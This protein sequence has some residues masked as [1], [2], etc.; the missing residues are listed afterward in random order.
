M[1][2]IA[3]YRAE[4]IG[5]RQVL[6]GS[7]R[8]G[9][10]ALRQGRQ[11]RHPA[12]EPAGEA[13]APPPPPEAAAPAALEVTSVFAGLVSLAVAERESEAASAEAASAEAANAAPERVA[14]PPA[15]AP[16]AEAPP[17]DAPPADAP[18][19]AGDAPASL[20]PDPPLAE[21]GFGPGMLIRLSQLGLHT[22]GELARSDP[23]AL[24][25]ALGDISRLVDVDTWINNARAN[26]A[27]R[28]QDGG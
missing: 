16:P 5:Q 19:A 7:L 10:V 24:R 27:A 4:R 23:A 11:G 20:P 3:S 13:A 28:G 18:P 12:A 17:A 25:Q 8:Q 26:V 6:R 2:M 9:R 15:E 22:I 14:L 1:T 21:I